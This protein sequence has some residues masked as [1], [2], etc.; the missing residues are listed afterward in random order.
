MKYTPIVSTVLTLFVA[1]FSALAQTTSPTPPA[2]E[3]KARLY[4]EKAFKEL[5]EITDERQVGAAFDQ[6]VTTQTMFMGDI[7]AALQTIERIEKEAKKFRPLDS[8]WR[9]IAYAQAKAGNVTEALKTAEMLAELLGQVGGSKD[10]L[11]MC[12]IARAQAERGDVA[13]AM[14]TVEILT[15]VRNRDDGFRRIAQVQVKNGDTTG[16]QRTADMIKDTNIKVSAVRIDAA[17][18]LQD[19]AAVQALPTAYKRCNGYVDLARSCFS[20]TL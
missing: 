13:G 5:A 4:L 11:A 3:A 18:P 9:G 12:L 7:P 8:A 10:T 2:N 14:A 16:A 1:A 15:D 6:I 19:E 17:K 20:V